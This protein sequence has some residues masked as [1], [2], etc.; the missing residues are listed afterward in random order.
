MTRF[1]YLCA[2]MLLSG[3]LVGCGSGSGSD[4]AAFA[5]Y[6]ERQTNMG[7]QVCQC[8]AER[9]A[10][11]L[12]PTGMQ[13]LM[14]ENEARAAELRSRLSIEEAMQTGMFFATAPSQCAGR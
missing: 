3:V 9:A 6:C 14:A 13:L 2:G 11:Q 5:A 1:S 7:P 10:E 4:V 8:V 12:S